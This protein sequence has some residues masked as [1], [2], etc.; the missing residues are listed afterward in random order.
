MCNCKKIKNIEYEDCSKTLLYGEAKNRR[1]LDFILEFKPLEAEVGI[2]IS[3]HS[4]EYDSQVESQFYLDDFILRACSD[5]KGTRELSC[6]VEMDI[7]CRHSN[8]FLTKD[9]CE[10]LFQLCA[11]GSAIG[12]LRYFKKIGFEI[13]V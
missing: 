4:E 2:W 10:N 3:Y 9:Q 1:K 11:L 8:I 5:E 13:D 7:Y 12:V 6:R